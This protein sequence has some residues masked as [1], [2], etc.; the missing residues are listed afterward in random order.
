MAS[1]NGRRPKCYA[2]AYVCWGTGS[3]GQMGTK[4]P[5]HPPPA[6]ER[7]RD[8]GTSRHFLRWTGKLSPRIMAAKPTSQRAHT[9]HSRRG[10]SHLCKSWPSRLDHHRLILTGYWQAKWALP[11]VTNDL[12][13][14]LTRPHIL[15]DDHPSQ[16]MW[17]KSFNGL[18]GNRTEYW[19]FVSALIVTYD[20]QCF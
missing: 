14:G 11:I 5:V 8:L 6:L 4:Y 20:F 17:T 2:L 12:D 19:G 9:I 3:P 16:A 10:C 15:A 1:R 7:R 18:F 13:T